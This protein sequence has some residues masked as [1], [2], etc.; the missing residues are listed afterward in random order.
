[1]KT[2]KLDHDYEIRRPRKAIS[3]TYSYLN[4]PNAY[5]FPASSQIHDCVNFQ[6]EKQFYLPD[7]E[8]DKVLIATTFF[9]EKCT[10]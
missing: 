7:P 5:D 3:G 4:P 2:I 6:Y 8:S 1:M 10:L 9:G